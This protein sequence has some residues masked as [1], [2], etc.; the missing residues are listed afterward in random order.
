MVQVASTKDV[1]IATQGFQQGVNIQDAPNLL[2]P[3]EVRRAEN[4]LF[5]ERGG[6]SKRAGCMNTGPVGAS[7]DRIIST[8]VYSRGEGL[9]PHFMV[10]TSAGKVYYTADPTAQP[11]VWT[12]IAS[13]LSVAQPMS[14]ETFNGKVY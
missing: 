10:H 4:G 2:T 14:W 12:Q 13:G 8:Y 1:T 5:D 7:T 9:A 3:V 6:F 11:I